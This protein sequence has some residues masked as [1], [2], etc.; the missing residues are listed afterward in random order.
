MTL[1]L[2]GLKSGAIKLGKR[3]TAKGTLM[4]T[5]LAGSRVTLT[6]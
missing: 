2:G 6:A 5:S 1:K 4:P 3:V